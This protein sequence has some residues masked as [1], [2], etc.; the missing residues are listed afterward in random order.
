M[1]V[2][3]AAKGHDRHGGEWR[4]EEELREKTKLENKHVGKR[5]VSN[6]LGSYDPGTGKRRAAQPAMVVSGWE[7]KVLG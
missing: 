3:K 6:L 2:I 1:T 4:Y 5:K 7:R